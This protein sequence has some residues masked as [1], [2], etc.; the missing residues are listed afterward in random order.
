MPLLERRKRLGS[1][2]GGV[3]TLSFSSHVQGAQRAALF[4]HACALNLEGIVSKRI[5]MPY[6]SGPFRGWRKIK[7]PGYRRVGDY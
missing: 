3:D 6:K 4:R 5:D 2:L 7:F 1:L